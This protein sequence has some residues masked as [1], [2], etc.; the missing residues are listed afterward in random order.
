MNSKSIYFPR[1]DSRVLHHEDEPAFA[2]AARLAR[3]VGAN[4]LSAFAGDWKMRAD[5][6]A[7]GRRNR[8]VAALA[9]IDVGKL[10]R[11]TFTLDSNRFGHMNTHVL[12]VVD[13]SSRS[14]RICPDCLREDLDR[15][16]HPD[17]RAHI[18]SWWNL[19]SI[20]VC[21]FHCA[22][23]LDRDPATGKPIDPWTC[24]VRFAAGEDCDFAKLRTGV[25]IDEV[26]AESYILG[27]LGFMPCT[28]VELLDSLPLHKALRLMDHAGAAILGGA[29]GRTSQGGS[30]DPRAALGEGFRICAEGANG[31]V[32]LMDGLTA[33]AGYGEEDFAP[34]TTFGIFYNWLV[35]KRSQDRDFDAIRGVISEHVARGAPIGLSDEPAECSS[36]ERFRL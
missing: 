25:R 17:F 8:E 35:H 34:R 20:R 16:G 3:R 15:A 6:I 30:I 18:R 14:L 33:S 9:G 12:E 1:L 32:R 26:D 31:F 4:S 19:T 23:M 29:D 21:P 28:K 36:G 11:V 5:D 7:R 2:L 27:R 13:W 22:K 24:D 10:D